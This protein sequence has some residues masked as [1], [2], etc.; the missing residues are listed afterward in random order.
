M[1]DDKPQIN[2]GYAIE[3]LM[4]AL[5][6]GPS[7]AA[8]AER[9]QAMVEGLWGG[10]IRP[11]SRTPV[12]NAPP[13]VTLD[14]LTG[15]FATGTYSAGG[16]LQPHE[17]SLNDAYVKASRTRER[18]G[19]NAWFLSD[20]GQAWL[21]DR[22]ETGCY[23]VNVPEEGALLSLAW[24][25]SQGEGGRAEAL[26]N[27][28]VPWTSQ[29]RFF[30]V[31]AERPRASA[32]VSLRTTA[33]V[34]RALRAE[35]P[36][37]HVQAMKEAL[38]VW[39]PRVAQAVA[40]FQ[41][42]GAVDWASRARSLLADYEQTRSSAR[43]CK[44]VDD[45][46]ENYARL[47][48]FAR[49]AL[50]APLTAGEQGAVDKI[51]AAYVSK[52]GTP[53]TREHATRYEE[54]LRAVRGPLHADVAREVATRL[55]PL[56][57]DEGLVDPEVHVQGVPGHLAAKVRLA[58]EA[59]VTTLVQRKIL[60]SS[61]AVATLLPRVVGSARAEAI[62]DP[63]LR[64][65]YVEL[66]SAFRRRRSLLLLNL[67]SQ[68][69]FDELPWVSALGTWLEDSSAT[70]RV[71]RE[72]LAE[73]VVM[74]LREFPQTL[75]PNR[76]VKELRSLSIAAG[77]DLVLVEELASDIFMG[78]FTPAFLK[79]A[80]VAAR[81]LVGTVY[82]RYYGVSFAEVLGLRDRDDS[83]DSP[84]FAALCNRLATPATGGG[85]SWVA[86]NGTVIEQ[87]QILTTHN[88]AV[89]IDGLQLRHALDWPMLAQTCF[90]W[91]CSRQ[92]LALPNW[93][94]RL[95]SVKNS[96]YA[97]RQMILFLSLCSAS[98]VDAFLIK[99]TEHLAKQSPSFRKRFEPALIGLSTAVRGG[100][101]EADGG[102][103][104][105]GWTVGPHW[106]LT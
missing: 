105:L 13:W 55:E 83:K 64:R 24:L 86:R 106:L 32:G 68:V 10:R 36:Q 48:A 77:L 66:Y 35:K 9:W 34:V 7:G 57:Q 74:L 59:P 99:A 85:G 96:A 3:Q 11:G 70:Q 49:R 42:Q 60:R 30:P 75:T 45:P 14:V 12:Q 43:L 25:L 33:D 97:W 104:F 50:S 98:D 100:A 2:P 103:R 40:L 63:Q 21:R 44:K 46:K 5:R 29:L 41:D 20:N 47:R 78:A 93:G 31:P 76:L 71:T 82:E 28:I 52:H 84:E 87:A 23:R 18:L 27:E 22:L 6:R 8:R 69:R 92:Q 16:T 54:Q 72:L 62:A 38:L 102:R 95:R 101:V 17:L 1:S 26:V 58:L 94:T 73:S 51:V 89:L 19:L 15:G 56:P 81:L 91:V 80:Q 4:R 67:E 61:E 37:P 53:G 90:E 79:S 65:L 88:L 39:A